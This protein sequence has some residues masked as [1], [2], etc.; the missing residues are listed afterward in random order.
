M[1]R[2]RLQ[3]ILGARTTKNLEIEGATKKKIG[4]PIMDIPIFHL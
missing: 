1:L 4:I 3:L 2:A